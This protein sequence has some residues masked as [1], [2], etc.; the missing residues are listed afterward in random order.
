MIRVRKTAA[1]NV[2]ERENGGKGENRNQTLRHCYTVVY[3]TPYYSVP[4]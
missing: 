4:P 3:W 1:A 2:S